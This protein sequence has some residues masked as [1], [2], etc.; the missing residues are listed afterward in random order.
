MTIGPIQATSVE[1][2]DPSTGAVRGILGFLEGPEPGMPAIGLQLLDEHGHPRTWLVLDRHGPR[3]TF[4]L[5]G[6]EVLRLGVSDPADD[7]L[8]VGPFLMM[9]DDDGRPPGWLAPPLCL[10]RQEAAP[11]AMSEGTAAGVARYLVAN[12]EVD[13]N[14]AA[15]IVRSQ[16]P[17]VFAALD[18]G[19]AVSI[20]G[21]L[22]A[23]PEMLRERPDGDES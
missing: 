6:D 21:D 17:T 18:N 16:L 9:A 11:E 12:Y 20:I 5:G 1:I 23:Q 15:K 19:T 2:V 10:H 4:D 22:L 13:P 7:A 8:V 14:G 3:L